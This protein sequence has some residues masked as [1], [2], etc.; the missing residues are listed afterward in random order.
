MLF[1]SK[2][3]HLLSLCL[4][5]ED[6]NR[7][8]HGVASSMKWMPLLLHCS[9]LNLWKIEVNLICGGKPDLSLCVCFCLLVVMPYH[10]SFGTRLFFLISAE[11]LSVPVVVPWCRLTMN[12]ALSARPSLNAV[13]SPCT[14]CY[15]PILLTLYLILQQQCDNATLIIFISTTTITATTEQWVCWCDRCYGCDEFVTGC[16]NKKLHDCVELIRVV[17]LSVDNDHTTCKCWQLGPEY[18]QRG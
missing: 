13:M 6:G 7:A 17:S 1:P 2:D 4:Y 5:D 14:G 3:G 11:N 8:G 10:S 9:T 18:W 12:C 16:V 15:R